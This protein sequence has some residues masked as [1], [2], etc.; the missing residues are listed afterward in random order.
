[1][2]I[3]CI[4]ARRESKNNCSIIVT[5]V[6]VGE[7]SIETKHK[8][9]SDNAGQAYIYFYHPHIANNAKTGATARQL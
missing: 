1:M 2:A 4:A 5:T 6:H 7:G 9:F 8:R 3:E